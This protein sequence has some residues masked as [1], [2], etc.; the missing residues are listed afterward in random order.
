MATAASGRP[1]PRIHGP[2][3]E[4]NGKTQKKNIRGGRTEIK[5]DQAI[6]KRYNRTLP[7]RLFGHQYAVEMLLPESQRYFE[8]V[9]RLS[10]LVSALSGEVTRL[11]GKKTRCGHQRKGRLFQTLYSL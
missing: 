9:A 10:A 5:R 2:C 6:V 11:T 3:H 7:K 1:W 4:I 8:R